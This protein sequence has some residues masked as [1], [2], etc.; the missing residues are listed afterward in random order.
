MKQ[1][2]LSFVVF[3]STFVL[4]LPPLWQDVLR[5]IRLVG[6]R[7]YLEFA[8]FEQR[9]ASDIK[10]G[11]YI[12]GEKVQVFGQVREITLE[13]PRPGTGMVWIYGQ[14]NQRIQDFY[15]GNLEYFLSYLNAQERN[16]DFPSF[17]GMISDFKDK[18]LDSQK[19]SIF[20]S[21]GGF[22][23]RA[24]IMTLAN[25]YNGIVGLPGG[26][27]FKDFQIPLG[28]AMLRMLEEGRE[29]FAKSYLAWIA[30]DNFLLPGKLNWDGKPL[31]EI[32]SNA[33]VILS[34]A[35]VE[36]LNEQERKRIKKVGDWE[37]LKSEIESGS[38]FEHFRK[39]VAEHK[40]MELGIFTVKGG[41]VSGFAE[42]L[43][44][45]TEIA[46]FAYLN[47]NGAVYKN[48]F[49]VLLNKDT[50][51][52]I[53]DGLSKIE[54]FQDPERTL[55]TL[56]VSF[57]QTISQ[58][59]FSTD[60]E[61]LKIGLKSYLP[62]KARAEVDAILSAIKGEFEGKGVLEKLPRIANPLPEELS[63]SEWEQV[64]K[65]LGDF[66]NIR[67]VVTEEV[68]R[69]SLYAVDL[70]AGDVKSKDSGLG[71]WEDVGNLGKMNAVLSAL[72]EGKNS[73]ARQKVRAVLG[74]PNNISI[75]DSPS[76]ENNP[77]VSIINPERVYL[78]NVDVEFKGKGKLIIEE[79]VVLKDVRLSVGNEDV[80][81]KKNTKI[82][83]SDLRGVKI[84]YKNA[85]ELEKYGTV[86]SRVFA[87]S[88][89]EEN[90]VR[91][92]NLYPDE[93]ISTLKIQKDGRSQL[94]LARNIISFPYKDKIANALK[95][96]P[97]TWTELVSKHPEYLR[98]YSFEQVKDKSL[99][100]L[101]DS[102]LLGYNFSQAQKNI[103]Y[104]WQYLRVAGIRASTIEEAVG[105]IKDSISGVPVIAMDIDDTFLPKKLPGLEKSNDLRDWRVIPY[106]EQR[107]AALYK[108]L[109]KT[110][111]V[112]ISGNS[113]T[114]QSM[115]LIEP[116][117]DYIQEKG[118][119]MDVMENLT[120]YF[121][122]GALKISYDSKGNPSLELKGGTYDSP[123]KRA[124]D[125]WD[126]YNSVGEIT[127]QEQNAIL[128]KLNQLFNQGAI[129]QMLKD[130]AETQGVNF[131]DVKAA[132]EAFFEKEFKKR[133]SSK[134]YQ[135]ELNYGWLNGE[136]ISIQILNSD[137]ADGKPQAIKA[138]S[139]TFPWFEVRD[140]VQITLKILPR[141]LKIKG[142]N[143]DLDIRNEIIKE[144]KK[145]VPDFSMRA[146]GFGSIDM[147][148]GRDKK[149]ALQDYIS[150]LPSGKNGSIIYLGDEF[151]KRGNDQPVTRVEGVQVVSVGQ[152][153][154][155]RDKKYQDLLWIGGGPYATLKFFEEL[156]LVDFHTSTLVPL[157]KFLPSVTS[158]V[159][160]Y[161]QSSGRLDLEPL[162][163]KFGLLSNQ[164][165]RTLLSRLIANGLLSDEYYDVWDI[166]DRDGA[167]LNLGK[168]SYVWKGSAIH[169]QDMPLWHANAHILVVDKDGN[170]LL[171]YRAENK[172]QF[173]SRWETLG[174][175]L[176]T[177]EDFR[178]GA[179]R[180]ILEELLIRPE[181]SRLQL[182]D[183]RIFFKIGRPDEEKWGYK[184]NVFHYRA[185]EVKDGEE[186]PVYNYEISQLFIYRVTD[187]Q[188]KSISERLGYEVEDY[189]WVSISELEK[190]LS[191]DVNFEKFTETPYQYFYNK[192]IWEKIRKFI[193]G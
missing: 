111:L 49:L 5:R 169:K 74:I 95:S 17:L 46:K 4:L 94:T 37:E 10:N 1:R 123:G 121:D 32:D 60:E 171:T 36:L 88:L 6:E 140:N 156:G 42:K 117:K 71:I 21:D 85:D 50:A 166:I 89:P 104:Q 162:R 120:V 82:L 176:R 45:L 64:L 93:W 30:S 38:E 168:Q 183:D 69:E 150:N 147:N 52:S 157:D 16:H 182:V 116:L 134:G 39:V 124:K 53:Y 126:N 9:V 137:F 12:E 97:I 98:Q 143:V 127:S 184:G 51:G 138:E 174:G 84:N 72:V 78:E 164:D 70:S 92:L 58:G 57:F 128:A 48:A 7:P 154:P 191:E 33:K 86:I 68:G 108:L 193:E 62:E 139:I 63:N 158:L 35:R 160:Y 130:K 185:T 132:L 133:F 66:W 65:K 179:I 144:L 19:Y 40:I 43:K 14:D 115:R 187:E 151:S 175:H 163:E 20:I 103:D 79:G 54:L 192:E 177:G 153:A 47:G 173:P 13:E 141:E 188:K 135:G 165:M 131:S 119:N 129:L 112:L 18:A 23:T 55:D 90:G 114:V 172:P 190:E 11:K 136:K 101:E 24:G 83:E 186:R 3:F 56:Q 77:Q 102:N 170:I 148:K 178:T 91:I 34:G 118:L 59:H 107:L 105:F 99:Y 155:Y 61:W 125:G 161:T 110:K 28:F 44:E 75:V 113:R 76:L 145:V 80:V 109:T 106:K 87:E 8:D 159:N 146:G 96:Y 100:Q 2:R 26:K 149:S 29:G 27:V 67:K 73:Q 152:N 22:K 15:N 167:Y 25:G 31:N 41:K 189:R 122:G 181:L 81:I 180:E 142:K